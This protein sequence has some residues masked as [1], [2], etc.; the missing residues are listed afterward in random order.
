M[1]DLYLI[2]NPHVIHGSNGVHA[3]GNVVVL[4]I[5]ELTPD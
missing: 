4:N 1:S 2:N 5:D 3:L